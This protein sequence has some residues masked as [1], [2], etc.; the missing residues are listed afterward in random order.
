[1]GHI[2]RKVDIEMQIRTTHKGKCKALQQ[3]QEGLSENQ[4]KMAIFMGGLLNCLEERMFFSP[5]CVVSLVGASEG[6][7]DLSLH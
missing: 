6:L 2:I 3:G 5:M 4:C 7:A 1:M